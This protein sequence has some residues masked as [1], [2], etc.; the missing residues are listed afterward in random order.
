M[1]QVAGIR[2]SERKPNNL[3]W[4]VFGVFSGV[5]LLIIIGYGIYMGAKSVQSEMEITMSVPEFDPNAERST[6]VVKTIFVDENDSFS[7]DGEPVEDIE[8]LLDLISKY[9]IGEPA[10][11]TVILKLH[12]DSRH[13]TLVDLKDTLDEA[14]YASRITIRRNESP[15]E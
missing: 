9:Q 7:V 14:G 4:I 1:Q 10:D 2:V 3:P 5:I 11:T 12:E 15:P 6:N 8:A 13:T